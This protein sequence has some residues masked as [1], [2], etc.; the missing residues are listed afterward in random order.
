MVYQM[1]QQWSASGVMGAH[2]ALAR[3]AAG[4][5]DWSVLGQRTAATP[6]NGLQDATCTASSTP[7]D[8][9]AMIDSTGGCA[10]P[11]DAP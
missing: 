3:A 6:P 4:S 5:S 9:A 1:H 2:G 8:W 7:L 10:C 11:C